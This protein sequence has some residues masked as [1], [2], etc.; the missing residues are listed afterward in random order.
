MDH[1]NGLWACG[2]HKMAA[3]TCTSS[4]LLWLVNVNNSFQSVVDKFQL[5][6]LW[7]LSFTASLHHEAAAILHLILLCITL[8]Q[9]LLR[10]EKTVLAFPT[11]LRLAAFKCDWFNQTARA[12]SC[13]CWRPTA[14]PSYLQTGDRKVHWI[15]YFHS[16]VLFLITQ[17]GTNSDKNLSFDLRLI[18]NPAFRSFQPFFTR[19]IS[20]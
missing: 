4:L 6:W 7:S 8:C 1:I 15:M 2:F 13:I 10:C 18:A 16:L 3:L 17:S 11:C 12:L 19:H 5:H 20:V 14:V 9:M